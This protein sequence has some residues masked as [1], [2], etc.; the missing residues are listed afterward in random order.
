MR[1]IEHSRLTT[2]L[3]LTSLAIWCAFALLVFTIGASP[4]VA[5]TVVP[6]IDRSAGVVALAVADVDEPQLPAVTTKGD[7]LSLPPRSL[8]PQPSPLPAEP[9]ALKPAEAIDYAQAK[10]EHVRS[11]H[12]EAPD[13]CQRHGMH[14]RYFSVGR[15]QS[16]K[17]ER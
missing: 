12:A 16:W 6:A 14:K 3:T 9:A 13:L 5:K 1:P 4:K 7:Q 17:C 8:S 10:A 11:A 15:G 2:A